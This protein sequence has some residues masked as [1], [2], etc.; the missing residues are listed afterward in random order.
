MGTD[1]AQGQ[2]SS[3]KTGGLGLVADELLMSNIQSS[4]GTRTDM[5]LLEYTFGEI[6]LFM[7]EK[8]KKTC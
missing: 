6:L 5:L 3:A 8:K 7:L 1:L 2:S 4:P